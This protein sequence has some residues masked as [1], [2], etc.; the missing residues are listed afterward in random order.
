MKNKKQLYKT[1]RILSVVVLM[2]LQSH[3]T[4]IGDGHKGSEY[5]HS[6]P[7]IGLICKPEVIQD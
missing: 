4:P 3:D 2:V 5:R 7:V 1:I 6:P